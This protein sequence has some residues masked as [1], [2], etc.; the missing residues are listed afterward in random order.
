MNGL[1]CKQP[2]Q[3]IFCVCRIV[4]NISVSHS[5]IDFRDFVHGQFY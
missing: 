4:T 2:D 3:V 1:E 5:S